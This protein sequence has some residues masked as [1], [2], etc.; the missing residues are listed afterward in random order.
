MRRRRGRRRKE[1]MGCLEGEG[2]VKASEEWTGQSG[3]CN[4]ER[5]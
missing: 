2:S 3:E 1:K 5:K 4:R